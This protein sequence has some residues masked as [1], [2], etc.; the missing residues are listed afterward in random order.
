M[1][2]TSCWDPEEMW[3][4]WQE[5]RRMCKGSRGRAREARER[6]ARR[7]RLFMAVLAK[8]RGVAFAIT[9]AFRH[10]SVRLFVVSHQLQ[11][12]TYLHLW[13]TAMAFVHEPVGRKASVICGSGAECNSASAP[14]FPFSSSASANVPCPLSSSSAP[15]SATREPAEHTRAPNSPVLVE[16]RTVHAAKQRR[17]PCTTPS[18]SHPSPRPHAASS[19]SVQSPPPWLG[20]EFC[21]SEASRSTVCDAQTSCCTTPNIVV[22]K[23]RKER[24]RPNLTTARKLLSTSIAFRAHPASLGNID[25]DVANPSLHAAMEEGASAK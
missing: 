16:A 9:R 25:G 22:G 20:L 10:S 1:R 12:C 19:R 11:S 3:W 17:H 4:W 23:V 15:T 14:L 6:R 13:R 5:R 7:R 21:P 18:F 8:A 2:R 24:V